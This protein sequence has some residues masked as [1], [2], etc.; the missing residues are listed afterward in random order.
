MFGCIDLSIVQEDVEDEMEDG[1]PDN[2]A[3]RGTNKTPQSPGGMSN[4]SGTTALTSYSAEELASLDTSMVVDLLPEL[5]QSAQKL[6][7]ILAPTD[8]TPQSTESLVRELQIPGS[9]QSRQLR[10]REKIFESTKENYGSE[11]FINVGF[12]LRKLFND[13]EPGEG[14]FRPDAILHGVNIATLIKGLLVSNQN[15]PNTIPRL[16]RLDDTFPY[17]FMSN[18]GNRP[19]LSQS[20][21]LEESFDLALE[22]RTQT[23]I[24]V[25][26]SLKSEPSYDPDQIVARIFYDLPERREDSLSTYEDLV[27]N[28]PFRKLAGLGQGET[29][30]SQ[31]RFEAQSDKVR[32]QVKAIRDHFYRDPEALVNGDY[33]NFDT[34]REQFPWAPFLA[35]IV[36]WSQSRLAEI[37]SAIN[38]QGRVNN[39]Q[40][41]LM[42]ELENLS[43]QIKIDYDPPEFVQSPRRPVKSQVSLL[44]AAEIVPA[45]TNGQR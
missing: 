13:N 3:V 18:F 23:A 24:S 31:E 14:S 5:W 20:A 41:S 36:H 29:L 43:S 10:Q 40:Q 7:K 11:M 38:I 17:P 16:Q 34:I 45:T 22:I 19:D 12:I 33:V 15:H 30:G 32:T 35:R 2:E 26:E 1:G 21:L 6:L 8:A 44:P 9:D 27:R 28:G 4:M 42:E 25:L 37:H 39:I